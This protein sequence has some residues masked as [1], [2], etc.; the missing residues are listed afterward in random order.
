M[1]A[2]VAPSILG[3]FVN[4]NRPDFG[5][6]SLSL[7]AVFVVIAL[8]CLAAGWLLFAGCERAGISDQ[9]KA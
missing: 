3:L 7:R 1:L 9:L 8:I 2:A 6:L 4:R 5:T